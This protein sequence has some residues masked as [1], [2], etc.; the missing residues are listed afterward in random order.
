MLVEWAEEQARRGNPYAVEAAKRLKEEFG[1]VVVPSDEVT[2][3]W[4]TVKLLEV[5]QRQPER[6]LVVE[7]EVLET[8]FYGMSPIFNKQK[9]RARHYSASSSN[10]IIDSETNPIDTQSPSDLSKPLSKDVTFEGFRAGKQWC[11]RLRD[12]E[13]HQLYA[14]PVSDL[15]GITDARS[16]ILNSKK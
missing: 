11:V 13:T 2:G 9:A 15:T 5:L 10:W 4:V 14:V 12:I 6:L 16:E 7:H 3:I 8:L 1:D